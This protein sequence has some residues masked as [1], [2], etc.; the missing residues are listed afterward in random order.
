M[1][2]TERVGEL[3]SLDGDTVWSK[4]SLGGCWEC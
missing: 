3:G 2:V 1:L 4:L